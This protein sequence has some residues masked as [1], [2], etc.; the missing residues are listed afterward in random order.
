MTSE[1]RERDEMLH[2]MEH[3]AFRYFVHEVNEANGLVPDKTEPG[4]PA[5][6][7]A[8]G[9]ALTIYP[10]GVER[11]FMT[12]ET[13]LRRSLVTLRFLMNSEQSTSPRATGYKGFYYHFLDLQTG[14]RAWSCELSSIDT[15]L[16]MAGV[17]AA[18]HYFQGEEADERELRGLAEALYARVDWPWMQAGGPALCH[19]WKPRSGFLRF[20][21]LGYDEA[22][23]LY[24]LARFTHPP[25]DAAGL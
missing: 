21:W 10:I 25:G 11:G 1:Q 15:A 16:L 17:L 13:A 12:R 8:T 23:I 22:L 2:D 6:I 20:H 7:A 4:W 9:M 24:V 14:R 18:R 5:S 19:G 3:S